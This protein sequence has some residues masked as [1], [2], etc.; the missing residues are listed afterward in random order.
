MTATEAPPLTPRQRE[1]IAWAYRYALRNATWPTYREAM[2]G[3][4]I[5][6][7]NGL[8]GHV[9]TLQAKGYVLRPSEGGRSTLRLAGMSFAAA[10]SPE[11]E[12]L[13]AALSPEA[14]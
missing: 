12:R 14:P 10:L 6:S 1:V 3:L 7:P 8:A 11:G 5:S 4:G 9:A 2:A 13:L